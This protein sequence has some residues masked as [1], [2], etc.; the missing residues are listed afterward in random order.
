[1]AAVLFDLSKKKN[2]KKSQKIIF[3][4]ACC[5][6]RSEWTRPS[7]ATTTRGRGRGP[8]AAGDSVLL[9]VVLLVLQSE[10]LVVLP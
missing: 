2:M 4:T 9:L 7:R 10:L 8:R 3:T 1:M 6:W 5:S